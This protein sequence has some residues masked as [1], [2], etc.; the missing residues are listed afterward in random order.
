MPQQGDGPSPLVIFIDDLDRCAPSKVAAAVEGVSTF[1]ASDLYRCIFVIGMDPQMVAAALEEAHKDM[2]GQLPSFERAV[3]LGWRFMDKFIQLPF[4]IPPANRGDLQDYMNDLRGVRDEDELEEEP[5][6]EAWVVEQQPPLWRKIVRFLV[7]A[8]RSAWA[9]LR[10]R[11]SAV[12]MQVLG[13]AAPTPAAA[14]S[15]GVAADAVAPFQESLDVGNILDAFKDQEVGNPRELKRLANMARFYL[16]LR[17]ER[18]LRDNAWTP[19][20]PSQYA[21]WIALT[22]RWPDMMR[23]L[24]WGADEAQWT[25]PTTD[26]IVRRLRVLEEEASAASKPARRRVARAPPHL[27][28]WRD[29]VVSRLN[30]EKDRGGHWLSDPKLFEFFQKEA[31]RKPGE[32]LSDAASVEFW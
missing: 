32:R 29:G 23:W 4:T 7:E 31:A 8:G 11:W 20:D 13:G 10:Q 1:L 18:K 17:K 30:L 16:A 2:R 14:P 3:P 12:R 5:E 22:S 21:R 28:T 19:P 24:Q 9:Y 6:V 15:Q 26:L 27:V 25:D